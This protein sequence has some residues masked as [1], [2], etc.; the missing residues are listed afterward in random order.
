VKSQPPYLTVEAYRNIP[1]LRAIRVSQ[2][3]TA[4]L[5]GV[6]VIATTGLWLIVTAKSDGYVPISTTLWMITALTTL[7]TSIL[8]LV[9]FARH[10]VARR[11]YEERLEQETRE[12]LRAER[13][14]TVAPGELTELLAANRALLDA[15]Q[16]PVRAQART[17][18]TYSQ[19]AIFAGLVVLVTGVGIV[20]ATDD[21]TARV[22]VAGL[23][24]VGS[25]V[26]GYIARTYLRIYDTAQEQLNFYFREP[27][28]T[29]YLLTAER[30][31]E[32]LDG[33]RRQDAY[34]LMV[35]EIVRSVGAAPAREGA[36]QD[37]SSTLA[38]P[39]S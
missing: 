6:G 15:Y 36:S 26:S 29:S 17:S 5:L 27:L 20:L 28:I 24:A 39:S 10:G 11:K 31:A 21:A 18:Y 34:S 2:Q 8:G 4:I 3:V 38:G 25:A 9:G 37:R 35:G 7:V 32:K 1:E 23:A 19:R 13:D 30:I 22:S 14:D 33:G 12:K 16:R